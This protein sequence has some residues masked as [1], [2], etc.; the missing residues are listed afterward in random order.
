MTTAQFVASLK[1]EQHYSV[2]NA[3][4][5]IAKVERMLADAKTALVAANRGEAY[6][7]THLDLYGNDLTGVAKS[8]SVAANAIRTAA[9]AERLD[10]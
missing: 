2:E 5:S 4:E 8:C 9:L 1:A 6:Y 3:L 7:H 10:S